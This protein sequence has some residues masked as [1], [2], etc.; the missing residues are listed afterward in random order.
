MQNA[1]LCGSPSITK[2][3]PCNPFR[4]LHGEIL[5]VYCVKSLSGAE[6]QGNTPDSRQ[7]YHRIYD[8]ASEG[9]LPTEDPSDQIEPKKPNAS[10]V[11]RTD[12]GK[13][14]GNSIHYH[15][16]SSFEWNSPLVL[17]FIQIMRG[18]PFKNRKLFQ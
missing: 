4:C 10:P 17:S 11:Q 15:V 13:K 16:L 9:G 18:I 1:K 5:F 7:R 2:K 6:E 14:Q 3:S 8:A 12:D